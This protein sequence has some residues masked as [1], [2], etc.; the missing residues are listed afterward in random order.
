MKEWDSSQKNV[1]HCDL[2]AK[3]FCE[4]HL[5]PKFPFFV[6]WE[7]ISAV[8]GNPEIRA[9]YYFEYKREG[10]HPDFVYW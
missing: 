6:D 8:Q 10:G 7:T 3:W 4:K 1:Y 9:L 5:S 2:C